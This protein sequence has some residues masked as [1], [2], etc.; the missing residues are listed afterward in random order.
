MRGIKFV[1]LV[2]V[3]IAGL[4]L[5]S[6][7]GATTGKHGI[8]GKA[9]GPE[10]RQSVAQ[11][12]KASSSRLKPQLVQRLLRATDSDGITCTGGTKTFTPASGTNPAMQQ[13]TITSSSGACVELSSSPFVVQTC[14]VTQPAGTSDNKALILQVIRSQGGVATQDGTQIANVNQRNGSAANWA[15]ATQVTSQALGPG[16]AD[17]EEENELEPNT[18]LSI[19]MPINQTQESHQIVNLDQD[20]NGAP[21]AGSNLSNI[22]QALRQRE[23]ASKSPSITQHQ[24]LDNRG[25]C[26][27]ADDP[28]ANQCAV[29]FQSSTNGKNTSILNEFY[30]EFQRVLKAQAGEQVQGDVLPFNGGLNHE[31]HQSSPLGPPEAIFTNQIE[32]QVQRAVQSSVSHRQNGPRKGA[33]SSQVGSANDVWRGFI[34]SAQIITD[35]P[36]TAAIGTV[37]AASP[38]VQDNILQYF[39]QSTGNIQARLV[40]L[41]NNNGSIETKQNSCNGSVCAAQIKCTAGT[42]VPTTFEGPPGAPC[43]EGQVRNPVTGRCEA[44]PPPTTTFTPPG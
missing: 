21:Q 11:A 15:S 40:A 19:V 39:G 33:G 37:A 41:E 34:G 32:R 7:V 43:P 5:G 26:A 14:D 28:N 35:R 29:V 1:F 20:T 24:N 31:V 22:W 17:D 8:S 9:A 3:A 27:A 16:G 18:S 44:L 6:G 10:V 38:G 30:F 42:C 2:A 13:C 12:S 23:R 36:T 4:V 25:S